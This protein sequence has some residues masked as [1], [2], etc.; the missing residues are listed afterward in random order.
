MT[1]II[2]MPKELH[3]HPRR[4]ELE[5]YFTRKQ[6][7]LR[8]QILV[9]EWP[10]DE[11]FAFALQ[12]I[13]YTGHVVQGL[14]SI[15]E[16]LDREKRGIDAVRQKT[17][18][19]PPRPR[20][21]RLLLLSQE[22]SDRFFRDAEAILERHSERAYGVVLETTAAQL[23]EVATKKGGAAKALLINDRKA[24]GVFLATLVE[25]LPMTAVPRS[26]A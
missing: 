24:L 9:A 20:L 19:S 21:A 1:T 11:A 3:E 26:E 17:G 15:G 4:A 18:E 7:I 16:I 25:N 12:S 5:A 14:E 22:G 13:L 2:R 8:S 23:G 10:F 6:R